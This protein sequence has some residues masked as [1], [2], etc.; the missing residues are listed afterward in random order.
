MRLNV[1]LLIYMYMAICAS[2]LFFNIGYIWADHSRNRQLRY[3]KQY[4]AF[5]LPLIQSSGPDKELTKEQHRAFRRKLSTVNGLEKFHRAADILMR[6]MPMETADF[7]KK[8]YGDFQ[9][10]AAIYSQKEDMEKAYF[11]RILEIYGI[12]ANGQYDSI[13]KEM[14]KMTASSS[15]Y[16]RENAL[17]ALYRMGNIEAVR[18]ALE[19][20][21]RMHITHY[22]KLLTDGLLRFQGNQQELAKALWKNKGKLGNDYLLAVMKFI[23]M[24]QSG[25]EEDFLQILKDKTQDREI[26]LEAIRYF[27]K[28][29][30]LPAYEE[31]AEMVKKQKQ[32]EWEYVAI[33]VL[34][35]G[36]YRNRETI[37]LLKL[38]LTS[39][40][41]YVRYNAA[42]VLIGTFGICRPELSDVYNGQDEYAKEIL[43]YM[44]QRYHMGTK[45]SQRE[46]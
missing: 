36:N 33:A 41:W 39:S 45:I 30:Y 9:Y 43:A 31:L 15:V 42:E 21:S 14:I 17:R 2:L 11:A 29:V 23:R 46:G 10:L 20:M 37:N 3:P 8:C 35:L 12:G 24:S 32:M 22:G 19:L 16:A 25:Y 4:V 40:N 26:R 28:Y 38:S 5:L 27:R 1:Q 7:L 13:K 44:E 34:S 18:H 6:E